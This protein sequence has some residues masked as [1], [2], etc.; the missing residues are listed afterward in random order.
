MSVEQQK[1]ERLAAE[2][3]RLRIRGAIED[4]LSV[5]G[6]IALTAGVQIQFGWGWAL[7][8]LGALAIALGIL[9]VRSRN[10]A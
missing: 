4:I 10:A 9:S 1:N 7:I 3:A 6:A 2:K 5:G 8:V